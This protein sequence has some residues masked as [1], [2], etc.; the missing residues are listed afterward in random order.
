MHCRASLPLLLQMVSRHLLSMLAIGSGV[1]PASLPHSGVYSYWSSAP[2]LSEGAGN[3]PAICVLLSLIAAVD[4]HGTLLNLISRSSPFETKFVRSV[5][6]FIYR[7]R[8]VMS[9]I[10]MITGAQSSRMLI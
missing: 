4:L 9:H 1:D 3:D 5:D 10:C 2:G 7:A 6:R 8:S